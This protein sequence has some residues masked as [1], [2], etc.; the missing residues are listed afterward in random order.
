MGGKNILVKAF[1]LIEAFA[2]V[3]KTAT[4]TL[5]ENNVVTLTTINNAAADLQTELNKIS[6]E[7]TE[8]GETVLVG[9]IKDILSTRNFTI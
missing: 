6:G 9:E 7:V 1:D 5:E 2:G 4:G 8:E 3:L